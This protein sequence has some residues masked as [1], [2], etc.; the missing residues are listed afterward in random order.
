MGCSET[1]QTRVRS[2]LHSVTCWKTVVICLQ[3]S[4]LVTERQAVTYSSLDKGTN[5]TL[6]GSVTLSILQLELRIRE[7]LGL[8]QARKIPILTQYFRF[9]SSFKQLA[10]I[11]KGGYFRLF[12]FCSNF[13]SHIN[14]YDD[15][16]YVSKAVEK[17]YLHGPKTNNIF[18]HHCLRCST[19]DKNL[20]LR[21]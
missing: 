1:F 12:P 17:V 7:A 14:R 18:K 11:L 8:I 5:S 6:N 4:P 10:R 2:K 9:F 16:S 3:P 13:V 15:E 21:S 19:M 20:S